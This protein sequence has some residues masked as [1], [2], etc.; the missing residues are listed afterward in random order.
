MYDTKYVIRLEHVGNSIIINILPD[1]LT[2]ILAIA[3]MSRS[4]TG[5]DRFVDES[6]VTR[7]SNSRNMDDWSKR[8][9]KILTSK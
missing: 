2:T 3:R 5:K 1:Q 4:H 8:P 6:D 9:D 7:S